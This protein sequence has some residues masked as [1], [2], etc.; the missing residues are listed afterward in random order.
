ML[1]DLFELEKPKRL[2][3]IVCHAPDISSGGYLRNALL[4]FGEAVNAVI[5][6]RPCSRYT[7][8]GGYSRN[9]LL[10]F[11]YALKC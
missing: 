11:G 1:N 4:E 7:S 8:S 6:C 9:A 5:C 2:I 3:F 10:E